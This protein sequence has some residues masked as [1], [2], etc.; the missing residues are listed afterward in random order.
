LKV[1][2]MTKA[3]PEEPATEV[4]GQEQPTDDQI[5]FDQM[6]EALRT[7]DDSTI[8]AALNGSRHVQR[9][10]GEWTVPQKYVK[11][12]GDFIACFDRDQVLARLEMAADSAKPVN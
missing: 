3:Q 4:N 10:R 6:M 9:P 7:L 2:N 11:A 12:M 1:I 8:V 5:I